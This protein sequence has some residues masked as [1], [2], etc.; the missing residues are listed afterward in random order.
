MAPA[1]PPSPEGNWVTVDLAAQVGRQV[2]VQI[3][4]NEAGGCGFVSFDRVYVGRC[5]S[6]SERTRRQTQRHCG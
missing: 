1:C 4:D 6:V 3:F 2:K 5:L